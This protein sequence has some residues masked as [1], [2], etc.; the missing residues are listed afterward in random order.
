MVERVEIMRG[1]GSALYGSSAIGGI[2]NIITKDP[3]RNTLSLSNTTNFMEGGTPDINTSLGG[4]F[5]SDDYKLGA[6]VFGQVKSRGGY[7]RN[8]DGFTDI[9][10]LQSETLGFRGYYKTSTHS[11]LTAEYH[12]IH[13][14]RRGGDNLSSAPHMA[15]LCEQVLA[16]TDERQ[17]LPST[18]IGP[19]S[20][21]KNKSH[22]FSH[23]VLPSTRTPCAIQSS[24]IPAQ[25]PLWWMRFPRIVTPTEQSSFNPAW[26][27]P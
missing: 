17:V 22:L 26:S 16:A 27:Q 12:H 15:M 3:V 24:Q 7:D 5:V 13:D 10:K 20:T 9:T 23:S 1:G 6:Y 2:V 8:G 11:R 4:A 21:S 18:R 19:W 25:P 14:F